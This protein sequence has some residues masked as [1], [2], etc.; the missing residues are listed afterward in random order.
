MKILRFLIL[1]FFTKGYIKQADR[2]PLS[3]FNSR[4]KSMISDLWFIMAIVFPLFLL[5]MIPYFVFLANYG[6]TPTLFIIYITVA[7]IPWLVLLFLILNKDCINSMSAGKR[8]FGFKIID[9]R[10]KELASDFQCMIRNITMFA[11]PLE[12]IIIL[13]NP[14]RRIGDYLAKTEVVKT[15]TK[16]IESL[17]TELQEKQKLSG[18]LIIA[19]IGVS[20]I[21]TLIAYLGLI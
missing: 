15:D 8:T 3:I 16:P 18:K 11:W 12:A 14:T 7:M 4:I 5:V 19:S 6:D 20:V 13:I 9:Y 17:M 1:N 10:T 2:F 21:L